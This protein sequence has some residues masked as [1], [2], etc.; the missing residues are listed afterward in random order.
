MGE[1]GQREIERKVRCDSIL[2][3][4]NDL[5]GNNMVFF[6]LSH[7]SS[8]QRDTGACLFETADRLL[9]LLLMSCV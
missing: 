2:L 8:L 7:L 1:G 4:E 5:E 6:T 3:Q 9:R